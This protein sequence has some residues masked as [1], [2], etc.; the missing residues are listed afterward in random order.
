MEKPQNL[1]DLRTIL[2]LTGLA[3]V[4]LFAGAC[5]QRMAPVATVPEGSRDGKYDAAPPAGGISEK[6]EQ[7]AG[8]VFRLNVIAFYETYTFP[9]KSGVTLRQFK[10]QQAETKGAVRF[11]SSESVLGTATVI[12]SANNQAVLLTCAH[13]VH[14]PDTSVTYYPDSLGIVRRMAIKIKQKSFVAGLDNPEVKIL[15]ADTKNDIALLEA[16]LSPSDHLRVMPV[17]LGKSSDL[18]WGNFVYVMGFPKGEKMVESGIVS[19]PVNNSYFIVN[20]SF[21]RGISGGPVF[22]LRDGASGMEWVG[23]AKSAPATTIFYL[24][25]DVN[26]K[27]IYSKSEPYKGGVL[28]N[29]KKM[30]NYGITYSVSMQEIIRFVQSIGPELGKE[31]FDIQQFF[32]HS[33]E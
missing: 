18:A 29:K 25:P 31:G 26:K 14:F 33:T 21:N 30:I 20:A 24:Q 8:S 28:V 5:S 16:H 3:A 19:K 2:V 27:E 6:L 17:P 32:Y 23:I 10:A 13:V 1:T 4:L 11:V 22:A 15:A 9:E 7:I 12:Y